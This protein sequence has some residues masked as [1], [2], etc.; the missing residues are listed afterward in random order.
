MQYVGTILSLYTWALRFLEWLEALSHE[1]NTKFSLIIC[2]YVLH[3]GIKLTVTLDYKALAF[4]FKVYNIWMMRMF[5][6]WILFVTNHFKV[7][8]FD[9]VY[10]Y[11][12]C[13]NDKTCGCVCSLEEFQSCCEINFFWKVHALKLTKGAWWH[14]IKIDLITFISCLIR[15]IF[16]VLYIDLKIPSLK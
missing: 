12:L 14:Y 15:I 11:K 3:F 7:Q 6:R 13:C 1:L 10:G 8:V 4:H 9:F 2:I 16:H 5:I